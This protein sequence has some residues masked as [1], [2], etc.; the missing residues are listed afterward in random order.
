VIFTEILKVTTVMLYCP[1]SNSF[2]YCIFLCVCYHLCVVYVVC[3]VA[4]VVNCVCCLCGVYIVSL[5]VTACNLFCV[6]YVQHTQRV[7]GSH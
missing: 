5:L 2:V 6:L 3:C 1:N 7:T 4:C